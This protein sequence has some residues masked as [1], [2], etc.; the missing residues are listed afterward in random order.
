MPL[1]DGAVEAAVRPRGAGIAQQEKLA[2]REGD[3]VVRAALDRLGGGGDVRLSHRTAVDDER[4]GVGHSDGIAATRRDAPKAERAVLPVEHD[5]PGRGAALE[6]AEQDEVAAAQAGRHSAARHHRQPEHDPEQHPA[7]R[8]EHC[9]TGEEAVNFR[10]G[11]CFFLVSS[12]K[13]LP[14]HGSHLPAAQQPP[15]QPA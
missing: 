7:Q 14:W 4:A 10:F 5:L 12:Q 13:V 15:A 9:Q 8:G 6:P 1:W 2:L 3:G 11:T